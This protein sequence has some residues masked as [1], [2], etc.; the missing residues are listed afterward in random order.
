MLGPT[1]L[2]LEEKIPFKKSLYWIMFQLSD[3]Y[4]WAIWGNIVDRSRNW[5]P[6][7]DGVTLG[8]P[9]GVFLVPS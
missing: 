6:I 5:G 9:T 3:T 4:R 1:F 7:V 2:I 8:Y